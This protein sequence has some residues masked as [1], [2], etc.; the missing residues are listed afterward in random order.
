M[1]ELPDVPVEASESLLYP[2]KGPG[3]RDGRVN[4]QPVSRNRRQ[5]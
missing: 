4:F 5:K 1:K 3:I 2:E